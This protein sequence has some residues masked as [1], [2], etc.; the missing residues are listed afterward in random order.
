MKI[1][2]S[3]FILL[4]PSFLSGKMVCKGLGGC[5]ILWETGEC[6][7][8]VFESEVIPKNIVVNTHTPVVKVLVKKVIDTPTPVNSTKNNTSSPER[9]FFP[10]LGSEGK[11]RDCLWKERGS[12]T[13]AAVKRGIIECGE[14]MN[15]VWLDRHHSEYKCK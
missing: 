1:I 9:C 2:L 8:C 5:P 6:I 4:I 12:I 3:I 10:E 7:G 11:W 14:I 13:A 15:W